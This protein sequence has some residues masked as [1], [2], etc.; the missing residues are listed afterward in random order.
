[1]KIEHFHWSE[2]GVSVEIVILK[3]QAISLRFMKNVIFLLLKN[4]IKIHFD[5]HKK[6]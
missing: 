3:F 2:N 4:Y 6:Q 1:M 5:R